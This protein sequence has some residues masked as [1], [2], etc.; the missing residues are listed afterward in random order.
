MQRYIRATLERAA[1]VIALSD[2]WRQKLLRICPRA[3]IEVLP[4]AV[5]LPDTTALNRA[6][7]LAPTVLFLGH[8]ERAKGTYDL[9]HAFA[10]I[11]EQFP[12]ARLLC[13]GSG[14]IEQVRALAHQLGIDDRVECPGWLDRAQKERALACCTIFVLP[15]YAEGLPMALLEAMSWGLPVITTPVGGIPQVIEHEANG[16]LVQPGHIDDLAETM[17]MLLESSAARTRLGAAARSTIEARYTLDRAL[18]RLG[19]IYGRFGITALTGWHH[20]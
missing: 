13:G 18:R 9:V 1:L 11:A 10:R 4:N 19:E 8:L 3:T 14:G 15:S 17:A 12:K 7:P 5:T 16:R 2:D 20:K 6:T